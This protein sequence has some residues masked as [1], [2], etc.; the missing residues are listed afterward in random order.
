MDQ[1]GGIA[2]LYWQPKRNSPMSIKVRLIIVS[3]P[4]SRKCPPSTLQCKR[5]GSTDNLHVNTKWVNKSGEV[6]VS[7]RCRKCT[8]E[9]CRRYGNT[10]SGRKAKTQALKRTNMRYPEKARA[11]RLVHLAVK[12]GQIIR[13]PCVQCGS[14]RSEGHHPDYAKPLEVVWLCCSCHARV[15]REQASITA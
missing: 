5:C 14:I 1:Q 6:R 8:A 4:T 12:S 3:H 15:H 9:R 7:Y 13:Q 2:V 10:P 11:R